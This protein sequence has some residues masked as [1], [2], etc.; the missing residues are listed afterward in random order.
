MPDLSVFREAIRREELDG[1]L[2]CNF[3][4]RDTLTDR[5]LGLESGSVSTRPWFYAILSDGEPLAIVHAIE[6][7]I[8]RSLPGRTRLYSS[9]NQ[10]EAALASL[11]GT[12]MGVL[13][14]PMIPVLSTMDASS[15]DLAV[16]C[17][18]ECVSA[19]PLVQRVHGILDRNGI[20]SHM[21]AAK[22]LYSIVHQGWRMIVDA[23]GASKELCE[24]D[25]QAALIS[26]LEGE[27]LV[28]DHP[29][30]V[31]AG[32]SSANPHYSCQEDTRRITRGD[33]VQFDIWAKYPSGIYADI[34]W[35]G[36]CDETVPSPIEREFSLVCTAR[37]LVFSALDEAYR[38]ERRVTGAEL[39]RLVRSFLLQHV[40]DSALRHR[41]GHGIDTQCHGSGVNLDSVEFPDHRCILEGSCFSVEPGIYFDTYGFRSEINIFIENGRPVIS[42]G[43]IQNRL[44]SFTVLD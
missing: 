40:P 22:S 31:G 8:L 21:R 6:P 32:R 17:G 11:S 10:L 18:I 26:L 19:A 44:L 28:T 30:I 43:P 35:V 34:S 16:Q 4:H 36:Y 24:S 38:C 1:W 5:L 27:G 2:F 39:D 15:R 33:I 13:S 41:T 25:V 29:P 42:G 12:R 7:D 23:F 9:R 14:D 20:E 3:A 37:D